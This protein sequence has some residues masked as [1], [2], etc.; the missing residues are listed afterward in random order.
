MR[1]R[2]TGE[3]TRCR[4]HGGASTGAR[5][6]EGIERIRQASLKHGNA[7][8][9]AFAARR[10]RKLSRMLRAIEIAALDRDARELLRAAR[11]DK[12]SE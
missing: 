4:I 6:P 1:N 3:Y 2:K 11:K 9:A 7:T 5:T 12:I 10:A 8:K